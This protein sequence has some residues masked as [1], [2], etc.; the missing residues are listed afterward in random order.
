M[1]KLPH[2]TNSQASMQNFE[3]I[4]TN[5]F[6]VTFS[7]PLSLNSANLPL[8]LENLTKIGGLD[9]EKMPTV[10]EQRFKHAKR[11]YSSAFVDDTTVTLELNFEVNLNDANSA[12]VYKTLRDW[13]NLVHDPRTGRMGL[14]KDYVGGPL[15]ISMHN[16]VGEIFRQWVFQT[17]WPIEPLPAVELSYTEDNIYKVE[18]FKLAADYW[19]EAYL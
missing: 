11:R 19:N 12:Y 15:V 13:C 6:E 14:K 18:G 3:P 10:V 17:V 7:P 16:K 5:L 9:T 8:V 4:Y 1:A 2:Y